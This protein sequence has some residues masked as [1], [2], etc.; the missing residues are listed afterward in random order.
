M[1]RR[2]DLEVVVADT[3]SE[4]LR[5]AAELR[6]PLVLLDM[7]LP[8]MDGSEVFARLK[9]DPRTATLP[10]VALSANVM[11]ADIDAALASGMTAYWTKPLDFKVFSRQL[12]ALLGPAPGS[13][14]R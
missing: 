10:C 3:G 9:A 14:S 7:Q 6:P 8:D 11:Q 1:R 12:D 2:G 4:G 5:L 13:P